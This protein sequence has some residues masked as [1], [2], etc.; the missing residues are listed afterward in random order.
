M[1]LRMSVRER[2]SCQYGLRVTTRHPAFDGGLELWWQHLSG[3][4]RRVFC[5]GGGGGA[6]E[7]EALTC[8]LCR[9]WSGGP[10]NA[11]SLWKPEDVKVTKGAD[12]IATY[13][14]TEVSV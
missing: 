4:C 13:H 9:S 2:L 3:P 10:V 12:K 14:K 8:A 6:G 5:G 7:L 11:F 1:P